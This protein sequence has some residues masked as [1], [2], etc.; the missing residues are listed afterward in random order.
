[1]EYEGAVF[2][3]LVGAVGGDMISSRTIGNSS[4]ELLQFLTR[5]AGYGTDAAAPRAVRWESGGAV[6]GAGGDVEFGGGA[7]FVG[8]GI[9]PLRLSSG[10]NKLYFSCRP[11][12][13]S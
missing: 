6:R 8:G 3:G 12:N 2:G 10:L 9:V 7:V 13:L 5:R 11:Q 4:A 1:M